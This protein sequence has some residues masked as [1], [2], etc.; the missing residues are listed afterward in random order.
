MGCHKSI[1]EACKSDL[2]IQ[3]THKVRAVES[4][5]KTLLVEA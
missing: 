3:R 1:G 2:S 4:D 5:A